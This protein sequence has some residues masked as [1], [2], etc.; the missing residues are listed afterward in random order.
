MAV[1]QESNQYPF[2]IN[3]QY[4]KDLSFENPNYLMKYGESSKDPEIGVSL[5]NSVAKIDDEH[6]EVT[7]NVKAKSDIADKSVF[8]IEIAYGALVTV[9]KD[10]DKEVLESIL[11][12]HCPFLMFPHIRQLIENITSAG[13]FP[14]LRLDPIDFA[15]L[16]MSK[17]KELAANKNSPQ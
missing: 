10:L 2:R 14:P 4:V 16:Y 5:E 9:A 17:K 3:D 7:L 6:F 8:V 12:V 15:S 11:M 13:G 1:E